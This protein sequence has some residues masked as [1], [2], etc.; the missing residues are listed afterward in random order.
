MFQRG[1]ISGSLSG[2]AR[3]SFGAQRASFGSVSSGFGSQHFGGGIGISQLGSRV[4]PSISLERSPIGGI[5]TRSQPSRGFRVSQFSRGLPRQLDISRSFGRRSR[6]RQDLIT[7]L[8]RSYGPRYR[9]FQVRSSRSGIPIIRI[10]VRRNTVTSPI[11]GRRITQSRSSPQAMKRASATVRSN[12]DSG[13]LEEQILA[14]FSLD[15][16]NVTDIIKPEIVGKLAQLSET[17]DHKTKVE[18]IVKKESTV[19]ADTAQEIVEIGDGVA[20]VKSSV[21]LSS[22]AVVAAAEQ[23]KVTGSQTAEIVPI[24]VVDVVPEPHVPATVVHTQS[25]VE[26][27]SQ[28]AGSVT[29]DVIVIPEVISPVIPVQTDVIIS[30]ETPV[31]PVQEIIVP[32]VEVGGAVATDVLPHDILP[33]DT[34]PIA[35][36]ETVPEVVVPL[37]VVTPPV[38]D[39]IVAASEPTLTQIVPEV[40]AAETTVLH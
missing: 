14:I 31:V 34:I 23:V 28:A 12:D 36:K 17:I 38:V 29:S 4:S 22:T 5:S 18:R 9:N 8:R 32:F 24:T 11:V 13:P 25:A 30:P 39:L 37:E 35:I 2:G 1:S 7:M 26:T 21:D 33:V 3:T 19:V 16:H 27:V 10:P 40:I 20:P 15:G 6:S